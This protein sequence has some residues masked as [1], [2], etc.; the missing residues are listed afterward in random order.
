M[1]ANFGSE[2]AI[3]DRSFGESRSSSETPENASLGW[4]VFTLYLQRH[5]YSER[6][7]VGLV[8]VVATSFVE[9]DP[10]IFVR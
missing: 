6:G 10:V 1:P 8:A 2:V 3:Q 5:P 7:V 4:S 9:F